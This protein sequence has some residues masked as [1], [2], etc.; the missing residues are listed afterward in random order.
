MGGVEAQDWD[1]RYAS[2]AEL[3]WGVEPNRWLVQEASV[4]LRGRRWTWVRG[5]GAT[6]SGWRGVGGGSRRWT[7]RAWRS[8]GPRS[9]FP[10]PGEWLA[11]DIEWVVADVRNYQPILSGTSRV[12]AYLHLPVNSVGR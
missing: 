3:Q 12:V 11:L 2:S 7:S 8:R 4:F 5:R 10:G 6:P 1:A 9:G